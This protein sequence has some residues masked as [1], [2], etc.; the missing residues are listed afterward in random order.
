VARRVRAKVEAAISEAPGGTPLQVFHELD[1]DLFSAS[2]ESFIGRIYRRFGLRNIADPAGR[3]AGTPYPQLSSEAIA[4][5]DPDL[6]V[7]ADSECCGQNPAKVRERPGW[8]DVT[9]VQTGAVV[10][11]DDD[12]ASRWGPRIAVFAKRVA[13][14]IEIARRRSGPAQ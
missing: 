3:R 8:A 9:A 13:R 12:I 1:P 4:A 5:A 10:S 14:A 11:I 6:V 7:L 2:S